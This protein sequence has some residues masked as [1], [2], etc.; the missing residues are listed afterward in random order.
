MYVTS[1]G[2]TVQ[3]KF[4]IWWYCM[5]LGVILHVAK[6]DMV[7]LIETLGSAIDSTIKS[8]MWD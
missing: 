7:R 3:M 6:A 4:D 1:M 2:A 8:A 5:L